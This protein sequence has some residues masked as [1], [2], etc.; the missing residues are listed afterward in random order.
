MACWLLQ[1]VEE[2]SNPSSGT[3]TN[4][5]NGMINIQDQLNEL[6]DKAVR[7][8][9][10]GLLEFPPVVVVPCANPKFGDYQFNGAMEISKLLKATGKSLNPRE[11][12]AAIVASVPDNQLIIKLELAGAFFINI[13]LNVEFLGQQLQLLVTSGAR[14]PV[15]VRRSKIVI[16]F[17]SPNIAKEMHVGHLRSTIIGDSLARLLEFMGHDVLRINHIGDWGTQFGELICIAR[18]FLKNV[19][20]VILKL[21]LNNFLCL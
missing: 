3:M 6:F 20:I 5:E 13:R 9:F 19:N 14:P 12:A 18:E 10:P 15:G 4:E 21:L 2:A 16:D 1:A 17:S 8:A 11:V 7:K